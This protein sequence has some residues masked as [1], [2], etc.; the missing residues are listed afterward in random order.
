[1]TTLQDAPRESLPRILMPHWRGIAVATLAAAVLGAAGSFLLPPWYTARTAFMTPQ[2]QQGLAGAAL[3][4][5]GA[6]SG[7]AGAVA[8]VKSPGDQYVGLLQ[9]A[10]ISNRIIDKFKL[11]EI[12]DVKFKMDARKELASNARFGLGK[13]DNIISIEV[14]DRDP[15]RAADM[16]NA[17]LQE[18]RELSEHLN[19]TEAQ[20]RRAFF[21]K[22][23]KQTQAQLQ[24][25][26]QVLQKSGFNAGAL[27]AE[28]KA[29]AEAYANL[30]AR[31]AAAE[32]KLQALRRGLS[33]SSAEVQS[34]LGVVEG[35]RE[36]LSKQERPQA[37]PA[38][39]DYISAYRDFKY[40]E[41][42]LE[43]FARQFEI[44]K[45]DEARESSVFQ[46]IDAATPPERK[47]RP[48]R[49]VIALGAMFAGF[50]LACFWYRRQYMQT[51]VADAA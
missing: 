21:E 10:T 18:L 45:V 35:L 2:S 46:V 5:L 25:A 1:M 19:L 37:G 28:P 40:Q 30:Q 34:Q 11:V 20:Q 24:L 36:Q 50:L 3:A 12:Y 29:A 44:A 14:D 39:Q 22:Y 27:K 8:G 47:S 7:L 13:K 9:S 51:R 17:Y 49:S 41:T 33:D 48:K 43:I 15:Q 31:A 42:L 16:A 23:L 4:S 32:V 26:Q 38:D 6:L